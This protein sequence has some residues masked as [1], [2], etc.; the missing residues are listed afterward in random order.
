[1]DKANLAKALFTHVKNNDIAQ[2]EKCL[3]RG[4]AASW[5][6][7]IRHE[8]ELL[9]LLDNVLRDNK[10]IFH[11]LQ[12]SINSLSP[13]HLA[14]L[15]GHSDV[16][17]TF[18]DRDISVDNALQTGST[19]LHLAS[20]GGHVGTVKLLVNVYKADATKQDK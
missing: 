11:L 3:K 6:E 10:F 1:M 14:A 8:I 12:C 18:F 9:P 20:F 7:I 16:L 17:V 13:L 2:V 19:C 5:R 4:D 15:L